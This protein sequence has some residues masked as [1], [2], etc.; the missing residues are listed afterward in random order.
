[1]KLLRRTNAA[2][3]ADLRFGKDWVRAVLE[4]DGAAVRLSCLAESKEI[5]E[6]IG[7]WKQSQAF[8]LRAR[9][10][11]EATVDKQV[12]EGLPF[13]RPIDAEDHFQDGQLRP[14]WRDAYVR[15]QTGF[16][17]EGRSYPVFLADGRPR[18]P[19]VCVDLVFDTF[20]RTSG[21]WFA[22]RAE[23]PERHVGRLD[24]NEHGVVN[25]RGVIAFG[26]FAESRPEL[27]F[28]A[29]I[30]SEERIPFAERKAFFS[31]LLEHAD[32]FRPG[33][34][35]AI[36]GRKRDG[37]IHQHAILIETTDP[38]TGFPYGL[39]DQMKRPRRRTWEGIMAEA[40]ARSLY[41]RVRPTERVFRAMDPGPLVP[42][43]QGVARSASLPH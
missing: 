34:V 33:D 32:D 31:Y 41:Y 42:S 16:G 27:F 40:P 25:R 11:M 2:L 12:D 30:K 17:Y 14:L 24:F 13:D 7:S 19:Q 43:S 8:M 1:V 18:P 20:E 26:L 4:S 29:R 36:Q 22:D 21:T 35:V 10:A 37:Y 15:G 23:R 3:V 9:A 6:R 5:V 38:V 39:A 28:H